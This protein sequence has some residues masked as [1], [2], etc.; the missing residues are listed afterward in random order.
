MQ[1]HA[2]AHSGCP[3]LAPRLCFAQK[4]ISSPQKSVGLHPLPQ[5]HLTTNIS[6]VWVN[7]QRGRA[8]ST[9]FCVT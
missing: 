2:A 8:A 3:F 6:P 4:K 5:G 1:P 9:S 7:E